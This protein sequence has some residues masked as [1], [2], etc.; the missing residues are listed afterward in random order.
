[1][2]VVVIFMTLVTIVFLSFIAYRRCVGQEMSSEMTGR[3]NE[4]VAN[5]ANLVSL[6]KKEKKDREH[7]T[8][9]EEL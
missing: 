8:L 2:V 1:V 9:N 7:E 5:Y 3:V 4:L 6:K